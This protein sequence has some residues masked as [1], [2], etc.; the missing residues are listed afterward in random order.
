VSEPR[1]LFDPDEK[2]S[3][4]AGLALARA[5]LRGEVE[6]PS[7]EELGLARDAAIDAIGEVTA[8]WRQAIALPFIRQYAQSHPSVFGEDLW[9]AGLPEP[10][11][12]RALGKAMIEASE[13]GWIEATTEFRKA[14]VSRSPRP[15]WRSLI[16]GS[17]LDA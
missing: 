11:D 5:V 10:H 7:A 1:T 14:D 2:E 6:P 12:K 9:K 15:V 4:R 8:H 17:R 3:A 16:F 13:K